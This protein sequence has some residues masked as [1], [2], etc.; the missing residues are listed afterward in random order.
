MS[1]LNEVHLIGRLTKDPAPLNTGQSGTPYTRFGLAVDG[2]RQEDKP[3]FFQCTCFGKTAEYVTQY[4][5][6]GDLVFVRGSVEL[7]EWTGQDGTARASLQVTVDVLQF[8][9][10][11]KGR[12]G[13]GQAAPPSQAQQQVSPTQAAPYP[14]AQS[15]PVPA[16]QQPTAYPPAQ[17]APAYQGTPAPAYAGVPTQGA[18]YDVD[19][20]P[21]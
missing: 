12:E 6:Q 3:S 17:P 7:S 2:R 19:D 8:L 4:R 11:P 21:F 20:I 5:K 10:A 15:Y 14:P 9:A 18:G 16:Q 13:G 1:R